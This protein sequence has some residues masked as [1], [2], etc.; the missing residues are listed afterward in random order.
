ASKTMAQKNTG[1]LMVIERSA[2]LSNYYQTGVQLN[3]PVVSTL[4]ESIFTPLTPLHDGAAI[5]NSNQIVAARCTLPLSQNPYFVHTL[6]TR[7]RAA[8]GLTEETDAVVVVVSEE[9]GE[10]SLALA[11]QISRGLSPSALK[12]RLMQLLRP[13]TAEGTGS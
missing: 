4:L 8:V 2:R 7:H 9:T 5:I 12:E 10:I 11:G 13:A 1:A 3:A 6:G